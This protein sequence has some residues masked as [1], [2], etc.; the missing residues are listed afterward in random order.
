MA[1]LVHWIQYENETG[2]VR[3]SIRARD[4][5]VDQVEAFD[6][7]GMYA[8]KTFVETEENETPEQLQ[9]KE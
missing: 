7:A 8:I 5:T 3:I 1:S 6:R 4:L 9:E 2:E